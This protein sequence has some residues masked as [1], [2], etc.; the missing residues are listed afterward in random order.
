MLV[1]F[2]LVALVLYLLLAASIEFGRAIFDAQAAADAARVAARELALTPLPA[3]A[4]FDDALADP[5]VKAR[6]FD[7]D[8][9]VVDLDAFPPG[10][11]LDQVFAAMPIVNRMLRPLMIEE[12]VT[13]AGGDRNLLRYPGALLTSATSP[14]GLTVAIPEVVARAN[15]GTETIRWLSVLEEIR[16]DP[17]D[18]LSGPFSVLST[19]PDQGLVALRVNVPFQAAALSGYMH[20][21]GGTFDPNGTNVIVANDAGVAQVNAAPGG[22]V[23]ADSS[24]PVYS[25]PFGLGQQL[26]LGKTVRP[27]RKLVS[28]QS[29]Y[30]RE[31]FR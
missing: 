12:R 6:I 31:V 21:G 30:R 15:D 13:I 25:G 16:P 17:A 4:T 8:L 5:T 14:T 7:P 10:T 26:A 20:Q 9:L 23:D 2:S 1:E 3:G 28:A 11:A 29:I 24:S 18:P 22:L 27:F 19:G